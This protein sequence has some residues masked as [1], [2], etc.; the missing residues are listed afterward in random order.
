MYRRCSEEEDV[1]P[2]YMQWYMD[3]THPRILRTI[4][5]RVDCPPKLN[6]IGFIQLAFRILDGL[7]PMLAD[8]GGLPAETMEALC[9]R[10][11]DIY[12]DFRRQR[13]PR[14]FY[15]DEDDDDE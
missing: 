1:A 12:V 4:A 8:P 13:P 9:T 5:E 15:R 10:V 6:I 14:P 3:R 7:H 2:G 11:H